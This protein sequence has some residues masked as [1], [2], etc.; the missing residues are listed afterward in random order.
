MHR[1][2]IAGRAHD[3]VGTSIPEQVAV[4]RVESDGHFTLD[5]KVLEPEDVQPTLLR[6]DWD[7]MQSGHMKSVVEIIRSAQELAFVQT[8]AAGLD[9]PLFAL[10]RKKTLNFCN[11]DAQAPAIAEFVVASVL[12]HW[13]QFAV[14]ADHQESHRWQ[15]V[16]FRELIDSNWLIIGFGNIGARIASGV[17][18]FEATVTALRRNP[19]ESVLADRSGT[20]AD[21]ATHLPQA[22]VVVLACALNEQTEGMADAEFFRAMKPDAVFVNIARGKLVDEAA[23]LKALDSGQVEAAVLD[24]FATEPLPEDHAFWDHPRVYLTPHASNRGSGNL[25]RGDALF[26][27]NLNDFLADRPLKNLVPRPGA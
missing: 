25:A 12:N 4:I 24:V 3:R 27:A 7:L 8:S 1:L 20:L 11:S 17:K 23:L 15:G 19:G 16:S 13:Q 14:R 5:G 18:G 26:L 6:L 21:L 10:V 9:N 22:D 2:L